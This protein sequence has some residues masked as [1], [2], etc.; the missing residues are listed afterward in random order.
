AFDIIA[1]EMDLGLS[2]ELQANPE[3][4]IDGHRIAIAVEPVP[5]VL[6]LSETHGEL[7]AA[8]NRVI[9]VAVVVEVEQQPE[10]AALA[11]ELAAE[12]AGAAEAVAGEGEV[13]DRR[14]LVAGVDPGLLGAPV[15]P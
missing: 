1:D 10:G 4:L 5:L 14:G 11:A 13:T 6:E 12:G 7:L 9:E 15:C 2:G 8:V 3:T